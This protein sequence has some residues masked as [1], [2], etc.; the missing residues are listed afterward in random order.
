M[1]FGAPEDRIEFLCPDAPAHD[2]KTG[3]WTR[4]H[5][6]LPVLIVSISREFVKVNL[7]GTAMKSQGVGGGGVSM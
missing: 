5:C 3:I 2:L 6:P 1:R 7:A 4:A